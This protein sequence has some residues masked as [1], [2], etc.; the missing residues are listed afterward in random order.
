MTEDQTR[1]LLRASAT[2]TDLVHML[3]HA[4][5]VE[6]DDPEMQKLVKAAMALDEAT[7]PLASMTSGGFDEGAAT[8]A[9]ETLQ[10]FLHEAK[11]SS[12]TEDE[13]RR[14]WFKFQ[15]WARAGF[16]GWREE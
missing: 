16:P 9:D 2:L 6:P 8:L 13:H 11:Q 5:R 14:L 4:L 7:A 15:A 12:L 3:P 10:A 1:A